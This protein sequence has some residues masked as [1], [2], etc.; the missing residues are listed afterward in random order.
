MP[1]GTIAVYNNA[2]G[3]GVI[4]DEDGERRPFSGMETQTT[5]E[6]ERVLFDVVGEKATNVVA[7][8]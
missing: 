5:R 2:D 1:L 8:R 6:G 4:A 7:V 3:V